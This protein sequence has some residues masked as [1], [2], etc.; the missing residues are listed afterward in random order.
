[1]S[2]GQNKKT[3]ISKFSAVKW[4]YQHLTFVCFLMMLGVL[5]IANV[6]SVEKKL[7]KAQY[8]KV[9]IKEL[10]Y[11]YMNIKNEIVHKGTRTQVAERVSDVGLKSDGKDLNKITVRKEKSGAHE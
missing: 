2:E 6:H 4:I 8:L 11:N 7:R 10:N 9:E 3:T 5:Y 1:M